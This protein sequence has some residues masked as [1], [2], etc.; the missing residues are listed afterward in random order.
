MTCLCK[1]NMKLCTS[2]CP[3]LFSNQLHITAVISLPWLNMKPYIKML[4]VGY[5]PVY[6]S[7]RSFASDFMLITK[8]FYSCCDNN[9][10]LWYI[11]RTDELLDIL[12]I[13]LQNKNSTICKKISDST[14]NLFLS[15][16][17]AYIV[18]EK[19]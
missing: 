6:H 8:I 13:F 17:C 9:Y 3:H 1:L 5:K 2:K 15:F 10:N 11:Y 7:S 4:T 18:Y 19:D 16:Y 14:S 12:E